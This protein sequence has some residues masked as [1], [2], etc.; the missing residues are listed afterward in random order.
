MHSH[1]PPGTVGLEGSDLGL[2]HASGQYWTAFSALSL[3]FCFLF[4]SLFEMMVDFWDGGNE[5][6]KT[7]ALNSP[8]G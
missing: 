8:L 6:T 1:A 5:T 2:V 7:A 3:H 4:T